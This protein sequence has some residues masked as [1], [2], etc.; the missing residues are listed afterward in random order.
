MHLSLCA[1]CVIAVANTNSAGQLIFGSN[2]GAAVRIAAP[3][4]DIV[5]AWPVFG[6]GNTWQTMSLTGV[7]CALTAKGKFQAVVVLHCEPVWLCMLNAW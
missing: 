1:D 3:G 4:T 2:F 6:S 5:S 7:L